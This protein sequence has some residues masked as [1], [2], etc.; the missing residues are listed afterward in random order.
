MLVGS[1]LAVS[2]SSYGGSQAQSLQRFDLRTRG[3]YSDPTKLLDGAVGTPP[4]NFPLPQFNIIS[5]DTVIAERDD[6]WEFSSV[7]MPPGRGN[8]G[9]AFL[10]GRSNDNVPPTIGGVTAFLYQASLICGNTPCATD[11]YKM[12]F[13]TVKGMPEDPKT[14]LL[15]DDFVEND[16]VM[17]RLP[18]GRLLFVRG[19]RRESPMER[20][21]TMIWGSDDGGN[22]WRKL[23]YIDPLDTKWE[24][25][26]YGKKRES[27]IGGWDREEV[28]VDPWTGHIFLTFNG[29]GGIGAELIDDELLFRSDDGG[30]NWSLVKKVSNGAGALMMTS[31]P[32]KQF[33]FRCEGGRPVLWWSSN[34]G[35]D[36][37]PQAEGATVYW[38]DN[39]GVPKP[40]SANSCAS[41]SSWGPEG[42]MSVSR[43]RQFK[44]YDGV[45]VNAVRIAY[46]SVIIDNLGTRQVLRIIVAY[47]RDDN[48][49]VTFDNSRT[50]EATGDDG[51]RLKGSVVQ[52]TL[53]EADPTLVSKTDVLENTAF[54]YWK[55]IA[56]SYGASAIDPSSVSVRGL[57]IRNWREYS[58]VVVLSTSA[59][60]KPRVW[61]TGAF[62]LIPQKTGDYAKGG[63][64]FDSAKNELR[65]FVQWI[66]PGK[67]HM[68]L[69]TTLV[70]VPRITDVKAN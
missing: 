58:P 15:W 48:T 11:V 21:G 67:P 44:A 40:G 20:S 28:Y 17:A 57:A 19:L 5:R 49:P 34:E 38:K 9:K 53:I 16:S 63:F 47:V 7:V 23:S 56:K 69:H 33:F 37:K 70:G 35:K 62:V 22:N 12:R 43:Y 10:S 32:N 60:G 68:T 4:P 27:A 31:L 46:P 61:N 50:I 42:S 29:S 59:D 26:R 6:L 52:A 36:L 45:T 3:N 2:V 1:L 54:I 13:P 24:G 55:Q 30:Q 39:T 41:L 18:S 51:E 14:G 65:Y 25:G 66:E 8:N 64:Y